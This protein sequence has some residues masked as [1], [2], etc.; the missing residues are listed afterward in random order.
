[1]HSKKRNAKVIKK[2]R[3]P[4]KWM[5]DIA[6]KE[7]AADEYLDLAQAADRLGVS[8]MSLQTFC[9]K[10]GVKRKYE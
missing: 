10:L 2:G 1:M 9:Y 3:P 4:A 5:Y 8:K 6:H 7:F